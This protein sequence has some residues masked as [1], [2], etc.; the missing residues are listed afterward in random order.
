MGA[1]VWVLIEKELREDTMLVRS[2]FIE[3]SELKEGCKTAY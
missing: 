1:E 3:T 2:C